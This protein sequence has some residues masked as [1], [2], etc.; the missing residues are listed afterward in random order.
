MSTLPVVRAPAK[1]APHRRYSRWYIPH[2]ASRIA[3]WVTQNTP[4]LLVDIGQGGFQI[5]IPQPLPAVDAAPLSL[6]LDWPDQASQRVSM[7]ATQVWTTCVQTTGLWYAGFRI[8]NLEP[9]GAVYIQRY[10]E[11]HKLDHSVVLAD[12]LFAGNSTK[13]LRLGNNG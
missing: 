2:G 8:D 5:V 11:A 7:N 12:S 6:I 9:T 10:I 4:C 3:Q 1:P 13:A